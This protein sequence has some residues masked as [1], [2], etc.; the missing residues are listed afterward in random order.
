MAGAS[1]ATPIAVDEDGWEEDIW[2]MPLPSWAAGASRR[3][4]SS[5][6]TRTPT[7]ECGPAKSTPTANPTD[8]PA[9]EDPLEAWFRQ[10]QARTA[11][12]EEAA[13]AHF[14]HLPDFPPTQPWLGEE[15]D[16]AAP[17]APKKVGPSGTSKKT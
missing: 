5:T 13:T 10:D 16:G 15:N 17:P 7:A 3:H 6:T 8:S 14:Q 12:A 4:R 1:R 9:A 11:A 2:A